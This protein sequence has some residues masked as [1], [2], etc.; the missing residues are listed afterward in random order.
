MLSPLVLDGAPAWIWATLIMIG[1]VALSAATMWLARIPVRRTPPPI[2]P[3]PAS[4]RRE[5]DEGRS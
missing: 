4:D 3:P 2:E 5:Q 1:F